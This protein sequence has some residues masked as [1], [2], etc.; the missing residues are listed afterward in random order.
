[1]GGGD[2]VDNVENRWMGS[3][4]VKGDVPLVEGEGRLSV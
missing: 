3:V 2:C 4:G 1:M